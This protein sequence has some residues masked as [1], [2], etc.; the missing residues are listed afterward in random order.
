MKFE[1]VFL[2]LL[3]VR[4]FRI[5]CGSSSSLL[6]VFGGDDRSS[7][8]ERLRRLF[9]PCIRNMK[10]AAVCVWVDI[11][12]LAFDLGGGLQ[13]GFILIDPLGDGR[14]DIS[15]YSAPTPT[16]CLDIRRVP[17]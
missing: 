17:V 8:L 5:A 7:I 10:L 13:C 1:V 6:G 11:L 14:N 15:I 9:S 16:R 4:R 12:F 3:G 2:I